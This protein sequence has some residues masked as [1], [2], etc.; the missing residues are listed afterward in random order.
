MPMKLLRF[1]ELFTAIVLLMEIPEVKLLVYRLCIKSTI[2]LNDKL[3]SK[4]WQFTV[5]PAVYENSCHSTFLTALEALLV[6]VTFM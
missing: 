3:F 5:L 6:L 2:G 4:V 1:G